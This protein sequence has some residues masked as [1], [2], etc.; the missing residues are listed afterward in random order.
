M[1]RPAERWLLDEDGVIPMVGRRD[2][3]R[4]LVHALRSRQSRLVLGVI[5]IGK[6]RLLK[7]ALS[8]FHEPHLVFPA[9]GVLHELLVSLA[10]GLRCRIGRCLNLRNATSIT[11]RGAVLEALKASPR[12]ILVEDVEHADPRMYR[13]LQELYHLPGNCLI[14]T[15]R[16]RDRLGYLRKLLWDPRDETALGPLTRAECSHLFEVAASVYK[17]RSLDLEEF[18]RKVL[19]SAR[20]NPGQILAMC[21]L[22]AQPE[23]QAGRHIKFL[24]LRMDVL[25]AFVR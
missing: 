17:L 25:P 8:R 7:E 9:P 20:G 5:G 23:Y 24:P 12:P 15:A 4:T 11:L 22:A 2:E 21:R 19:A 18:R 1:A 6:T 10:E 14:V 16:S 13:F 3:V